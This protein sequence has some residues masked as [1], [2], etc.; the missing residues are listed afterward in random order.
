MARK[1]AFVNE[2]ILKSRNQHQQTVPRDVQKA[3]T[4][5]VE[6]VEMLNR[7]NV[8]DQDMAKLYSDVLQK[9]LTA[10]E[11]NT[12]TGNLSPVVTQTTRLSIYSNESILE[13]VPKNTRHERKTCSVSLDKAEKYIGKTMAECRI[14]IGKSRTVTLQFD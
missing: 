3:A 1:T 2:L 9:Y 10:K 4:F 14:K 8:N 5:D 13:T 12:H 11:Q 7:K 6:V